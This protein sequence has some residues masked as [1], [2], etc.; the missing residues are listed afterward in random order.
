MAGTHRRPSPD[1]KKG[2]E[3][4]PVPD[5]K[6][7][8]NPGRTTTNPAGDV[9]RDLLFGAR[10]FSFYQA[11]RLLRH[12]LRSGKEKDSDI[13]IRPKLALAFPPGDIDRIDRIDNDDQTYF[14]I[15]A[16]FLG[17]YGAASPLPTFYTE[18]LISEQSEDE[19]VSRDFLDIIH[20]RLYKLV[21]Q[22]WL[23]YRQYL[24][25]VEDKNALNLERLYCLVGLGTRALQNEREDNYRLL[26]YIGLLTQFPRSAMGLK[27]LLTD[28][29]SG[30][31]LTVIPCISRT[32]RIPLDQQCRLGVSGSMMGMDSYM[33]EEIEDRMGKLGIR[34]G[35][36][37]QA[38]FLR[39]T[40]GNEGYE[41]LVSL[42]AIYLTDP[43]VLEVELVLA[44]NEAETVCLGDP[45]RATL[46][47]TTWVFSETTL[48][49]V[50]TRFI[51]KRD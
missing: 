12:G 43:L 32:A 15:T 20:Q 22:G 11:M 36:L 45:I 26:R 46:G 7:R 6:S 30:L 50:R 40:P 16:T 25:V 1:L 49:E 29:L 17:L 19:S 35:P 34:I 28:A 5:R 4:N 33:G 8:P 47:V 48:G 41:R 18:D 14:Q 3:K 13:R 42:T 23:K 38:D 21:Y 9:S 27:S 51:V 24:Q 31:P 10:S 37:E 44:A 2:P 39:F